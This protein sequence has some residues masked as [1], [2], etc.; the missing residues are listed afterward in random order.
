MATSRSLLVSQNMCSSESE[1]G[2]GWHG[3]LTPSGPRHWRR[4]VIVRESFEYG[5]CVVAEAAGLAHALL[6]V[7]ANGAHSRHIPLDASAE[8]SLPEWV[9]GLGDWPTGYITLGSVLGRN[10]RP[11]SMVLAALRDELM[12]VIVTVEAASGAGLAQTCT[13]AL[14]KALNHH[15]RIRTSATHGGHQSDLEMVG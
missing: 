8:K 7:G 9:V 5:G 13:G 2:G 6:E 10:T 14:K 11:L 1:P 12:N 3:S 15:D 4:A